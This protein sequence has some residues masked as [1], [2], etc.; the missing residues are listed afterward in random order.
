MQ[1]EKDNMSEKLFAGFMIGMMTGCNPDKGLVDLWQWI[2]T[3]FER[4][5][6]LILLLIFIA[7]AI[8]LWRNR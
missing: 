2:Q 7:I 5:W 3:L 6:L 8:Q 4:G 1:R